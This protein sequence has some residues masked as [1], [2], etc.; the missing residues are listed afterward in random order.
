VG[1]QRLSQIPFGVNYY[2]YT[3]TTDSTTVTVSP[4]QYGWTSANWHIYQQAFAQ[5]AAKPAEK[6]PS[7]PRPENEKDWLRKRVREVMWRA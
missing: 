3:T 1:E 4:D 2:P 7:Q 6:K 5:Q